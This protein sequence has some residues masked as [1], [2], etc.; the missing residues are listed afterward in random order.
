MHKTL[1]YLILVDAPSTILN[2]SVPHTFKT[3]VPQEASSVLCIAKCVIT[4]KR[5]TTKRTKKDN[6]TQELHLDPVACRDTSTSDRSDLKEEEEIKY[7][8]PL[9]R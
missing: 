3:R 8:P 9:K 2:L 1:L 7:S 5:R 6:K 4:Y